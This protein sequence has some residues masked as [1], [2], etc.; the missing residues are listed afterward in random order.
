MDN[1]NKD[2]NNNINNN[3]DNVVFNQTNDEKIDRSN[4]DIYK[5]DSRYSTDRVYD[6]VNNYNTRNDYNGG[7]NYNGG[8]DN[9]GNEFRN[10]YDTFN[11]NSNGNYN[12]QNNDTKNHGTKKKGKGKR[13]ALFVC[14]A[15][16]TTFI[17]GAIGAGT[18]L[19]LQNNTTLIDGSNVKKVVYEVPKFSD[20]KAMSTIDAINKVKSAVVTVSVKS[21]KQ[22]LFG[23]QEAESGVG[24]GFIIDK[25]GQIMTNY[26]V[27]EGASSVKVILSTG[28]EVNA[29]VVN[30][31]SSL[32]LA[33][34][35]ITDENVEIPGVAELG[36]SDRLQQG[37]EVI[38]IGSPLGKQFTGTTTK[39][40]ISG[41][42]RT[43][44][45]NKDG[46]TSDTAERYIQTDASI[47]P[48]N[49]GGP[50]INP[51]GQVIG[52]NTAKINDQTVEGMGFSIPINIAKEKIPSLS[53]PLLKVGISYK[54]VTEDLSKQYNL[55]VGV[56]VASVEEFGPAAKAGIQ[57][58]DV[59]TE[60]GGKKIKTG[61]ELNAIKNEHNNGD[62][63][64]VVVSRDG[65]D[66]TLNLTLQES[67]N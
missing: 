41:L 13:V 16:V 55:P 11:Y 38:A 22:G 45:E 19:Y 66:K 65:K 2:N 31:D 15:L 33:I 10:P 56:W 42:N 25:D 26:H 61:A 18:V 49:S 59:I 57:V 54:D 64:K 12:N 47:N 67:Q 32:D 7:N 24:S 37:E 23:Q 50:L 48:G 29:K 4:D 34:L 21:I 3:E 36:D 35:K 43:V 62:V 39:G 46:S 14:G 27:V 8:S 58:G 28:K 53:K 44:G 51:Q 20:E 1:Y 60:F 63:V 5:I 9:K 17:G 52:I 40:I 30:Y 6:D